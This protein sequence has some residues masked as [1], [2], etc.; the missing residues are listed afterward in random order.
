MEKAWLLGL[1]VVEATT[2]VLLILR[3][4]RVD[5]WSRWGLLSAHW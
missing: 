2:A 4:R 1:A 3:H 5:I